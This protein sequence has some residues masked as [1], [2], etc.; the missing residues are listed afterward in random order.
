MKRI[1]DNKILISIMLIFY[2]KPICFQYFSSLKAIENI[3]VYGKIFIALIVL[4]ESIIQTLTTCKIKINNY[5]IRIL[6]FELSIVL[7]TI[8]KKG[9]IFRSIIDLVTIFTFSLFIIKIFFK[10]KRI[11]LEAIKNVLFL[12]VVIQFFTEIIFPNGMPADLYKNNDMNRLFFATLDN[13]TTSLVCS[14]IAVLFLSKNDDKRKV[15][16]YMQILIC[17]VTVILSAS[18]TGIFCSLVLVLVYYLAKIKDLKILDKWYVWLTIY[19]IIWGALI[20]GNGIIYNLLFNMTGKAGFTGRN[21]LWEN[22]IEMIKESPII[23]YGRQEVDYLSVW[24]GYYSSHNMMLEMLLQGGIVALTFWWLMQIEVF[25]N[26]NEISNYKNR[27]IV[28]FTI[29]VLLIALL[30]ESKVHSVYLYLFTTVYWCMSN[31]N[32]KEKN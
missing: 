8:Y 31:Y 9:A 21:F 5:L 24:G 26:S 4:G 32:L 3:F 22:A 14:T 19:F 2:F 25:R 23:G 16:L 6:L 15:I 7:I 29:F 18:K 12:I 13:G 10:N 20:S 17:I 11:L 30:M 1:Y 27:R 28:F